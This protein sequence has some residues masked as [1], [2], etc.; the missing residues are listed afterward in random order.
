MALGPD[1]LVLLTGQA[2][3]TDLQASAVVYLRTL[4]KERQDLFPKSSGTRKPL[5]TCCPTWAI[6]CDM[7]MKEPGNRSEVE[8]WTGNSSR[9]QA[10]QRDAIECDTA[11]PFSSQPR[12]PRV[13]SRRGL[14]TR[15]CVWWREGPLESF[16]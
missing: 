13:E 8:N 14:G 12:R 2:R 10:E 5:M 3:Q 11:Q 6:I 9:S 7:L 15:A 1:K 16:R 4:L